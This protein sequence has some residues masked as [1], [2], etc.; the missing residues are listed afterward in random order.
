MYW[1]TAALN[2]RRITGY[3]DW[4]ISTLFHRISCRMQRRCLNQAKT[5][6]C[7]IC[8]SLIFIINFTLTLPHPA[9][10][11]ET[12][13]L[14]LRSSYTDYDM[15]CTIR[16]SAAGMG[17]TSSLSQNVQSVSDKQ[18]ASCEIV[19]GGYFLQ[20]EAEHSP[21]PR[22]EFINERNSSLSVWLHG[23]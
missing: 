13:D 19:T 17:K 5:A 18:L 22:A 11:V 7:Q 23:M 14:G 21:P 16:G 10:V 6:Y 8:T 2:P 9:C 20:V 4:I 12:Q 1:E 15:V 3:P